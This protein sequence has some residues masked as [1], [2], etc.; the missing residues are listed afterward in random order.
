MLLLYLDASI[1]GTRWKQIYIPL[2]FY[3]IF[4]G[5]NKWQDRCFIYIPLCFYFISDWLG[6][7]LI[8]STFT[9]HYASTLSPEG[10]HW[11]RSPNP[12]YIPL[13]FYFIY[14][15]SDRL[16]SA[17]YDLHS[18]ML[19]LYSL[20]EWLRALVVQY[21]HSTMLLLYPPFPWFLPGTPPYLHSTM[22]LLYRRGYG[23]SE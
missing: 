22:L 4:A 1:Y 11:F 8:H 3:F 2:C 9:F 15:L 5:G 19:L 16:Q 14:R 23:D 17:L 18:T 10:L 7:H 13:C 6:R 12:I 20:R 21:L